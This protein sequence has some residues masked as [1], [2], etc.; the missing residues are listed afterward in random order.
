MNRQIAYLLVNFGY[1][2]IV[3]NRFPTCAIFCVAFYS[4]SA[5]RLFPE[6]GLFLCANPIKNSPHIN[7]KCFASFYTNILFCR[8]VASLH[9]KGLSTFVCMSYGTTYFDVRQISSIGRQN[10]IYNVDNPLRYTVPQ[11][12]NCNWYENNRVVKVLLDV[13]SYCYFVNSG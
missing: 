1:Y 4:N 8:I 6:R 13:G 12:S 5:N 2:S 3:L 11:I 7:K 9:H 10:S